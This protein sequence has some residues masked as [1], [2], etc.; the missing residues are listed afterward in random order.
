MVG[1]P[2]FAEVVMAKDTDLRL[3]LITC[4]DEMVGI[5]KDIGENKKTTDACDRRERELLQEVARLEEK[6]QEVFMHI[7]KNRRDKRA[8]AQNTKRLEEAYCAKGR[9]L[10]IVKDMKHDK[11]AYVC[12]SLTSDEM[13]RIVKWS[14][15]WNHASI[16]QLQTMAVAI[17]RCGWAK[18]GANTKSGICTTR[19]RLADDLRECKES[20]YRYLEAILERRPVPAPF[21]ALAT[22]PE[23]P[24]ALVAAPTAASTFDMLVEMADGD[25]EKLSKLTKMYGDD[26]GLYAAI[27]RSHMKRKREPQAE[28]ATHS[29]EEP[30]PEQGPVKRRRLDSGANEVS[31]GL[32][33]DNDAQG[34]ADPEP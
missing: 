30:R 9:K 32:D 11:L 20:Y 33:N 1:G 12:S 2:E 23:A 34:A 7:E 14:K 10:H 25:E 17:D 24:Q 29:E 18:T 3:L 4:E 16:A 22:H 15:D 27:G 31:G 6:Q 5:Q 19:R 21:S 26:P 13:K 8:V 28:E